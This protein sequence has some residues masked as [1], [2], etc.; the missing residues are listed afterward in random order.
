LIDALLE[1]LKKEDVS[2]DILNV[3]HSILSGNCCA[4]CIFRLEFDDNTSKEIYEDLPLSGN[5][6]IDDISLLKES[7]WE[8]GLQST[9]INNIRDEVEMLMRSREAFLKSEYEGVL[10]IRSKCVGIINFQ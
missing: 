1:Y 10:N 6:E 9:N 2:G 5:A 4:R 7:I 8:E 3:K